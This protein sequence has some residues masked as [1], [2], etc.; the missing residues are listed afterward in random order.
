[1]GRRTSRCDSRA[2]RSR[3]FRRAYR[4]GQRRIGLGVDAENPT[5]ANPVYERAGMTVAWSAAMFEKELDR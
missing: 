2:S 3:R 5:G 1:M 4:C